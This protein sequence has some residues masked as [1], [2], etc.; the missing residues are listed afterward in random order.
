MALSILWAGLLGAGLGLDRSLRNLRCGFAACAASAAAGGF[1]A[2]DIRLSGLADHVWLWPLAA[3]ASIVA[4]GRYLSATT[5]IDAVRPAHEP[6]AA[7]LAAY[8]IG[9]SLGLGANR[10]VGLMVLVALFSLAWRP[11]VA[12]AA[13]TGPE[14]SPRPPP[15]T[16]PSF[17]PFEF[18]HVRRGPEE[19]RDDNERGD[20]RE[21]ERQGEQ[22]AHAGGAGMAG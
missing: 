13:A 19:G 20:Q 4:L 5:S 21:E 1:L 22:L 3:A 16:A 7:L 17:P 12:A 18:V 2:N 14:A 15:A 9:M 6:L 10:F 8:A 11:R